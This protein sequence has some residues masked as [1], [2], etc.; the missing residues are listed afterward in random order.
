M[1]GSLI[2]RD[3]GRS[4][5]TLGETIKKNLDLNGLSTCMVY[6]GLDGLFDRRS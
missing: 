2:V 4:R 1:E 5:K 6:D 3:R